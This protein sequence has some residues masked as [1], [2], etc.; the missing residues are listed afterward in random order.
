MSSPPGPPGGQDPYRKDEGPT[1]YRLEDWDVPGSYSAPGDPGVG[2]DGQQTNYGSPGY[3][4]PDQGYGPD[5]YGPPASAPPGSGPPDYGGFGPPPPPP[6]K[7]KTGLIIG[8]VAG[9]VALVLCAGVVVGGVIWFNSGSG[10]GTPGSGPSS[11]SAGGG[12]SDPGGGGGAGKHTLPNSP[13]TVMNDTPFRTAFSYPV[14][15]GAPDV[16]TYNYIFSTS[17]CE[18]EYEAGDY[19]T[20]NH[21]S[22]TLEIEAS[23]APTKGSDGKSPDQAAQTEYDKNKGSTTI[24]GV[25]KDVT[26][27]G[28]K[29][30]IINATKDGSMDYE[31]GV[32]DGNS[33]LTIK[34]RA[35]GDG[36]AALT[37]AKVQPALESIARTALTKY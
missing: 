11:P 36:S 9:C 24:S 10:G 8:I 20:N 37:S 33:I 21:V 3:G 1:E 17:T 6:K 30:Y 14:D 7:S 34:V 28:T 23:I 26:G 35:I 27:V 16:Q 15:Q 5:P 4:P 12:T 25:P 22:T 18:F 2:P 29:G 19:S 31:F 13:C 32:L